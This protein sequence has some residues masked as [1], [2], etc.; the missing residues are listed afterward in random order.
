[1][2]SKVEKY[3]PIPKLDTIFMGSLRA[4]LVNTY[5]ASETNPR[6]TVPCNMLFTQV[7]YVMI[8]E[9]KKFEKFKYN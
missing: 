4:T 7:K 6:G 3:V 5:M 2:F 8:K 9:P 1:M